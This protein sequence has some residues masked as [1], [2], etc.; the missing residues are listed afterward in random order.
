MIVKKI[1]NFESGWF[2]GDFEPSI[3]KKL[4]FEAGYKFHKKGEF[5]SK[6]YHLVATEYNYLI[7]GKM[8]INDTEINAGDIFIIPPKEVSAPVFL[9]DCQVFIIKVP[10]VPGDKYEV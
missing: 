8:M 1:S 2:I 10:S 4:G 5:W 7:S 9:E 3:A 6:H